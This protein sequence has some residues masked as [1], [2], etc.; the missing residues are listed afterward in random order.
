MAPQV[1]FDKA[2]RFEAAALKRL[3]QPLLIKSVSK[4]LALLSV[5]AVPC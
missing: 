4:V 3:V 1:Y 5:Q 2:C